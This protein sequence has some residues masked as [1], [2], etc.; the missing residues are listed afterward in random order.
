MFPSSMQIMC[1]LLNCLAICIIPKQ[2][3]QCFTEL[4]NVFLMHHFN[5]NSMCKLCV[6]TEFFDNIHYALFQN[7]LYVLQNCL[8]HFNVIF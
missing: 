4:L 1:V 3:I 8:I 7:R 6:F 2:V 5:T